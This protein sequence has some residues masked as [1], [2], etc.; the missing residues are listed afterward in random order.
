MKSNLFERSET[1]YYPSDG[2][3]SAAEIAYSEACAA[4]D[5][6]GRGQVET[7]YAEKVA[8]LRAELGL[9]QPVTVEAQQAVIPSPAL[10]AA[11]MAVKA[12]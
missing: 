10:G 6:A 7:W 2:R 3:R 11:E 9:A 12:F 8:P 1:G 5:Q 4:S